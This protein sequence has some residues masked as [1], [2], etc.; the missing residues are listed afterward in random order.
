MTYAF[1]TDPVNGSPAEVVL[2]R[3]GRTRIV[4]YT[5]KPLSDEQMQ[6]LYWTVLAM[7]RTGLRIKDLFV[8]DKEES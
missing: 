8:K 7:H 1:M 3:D 6:D 5:A 2:R 4:V